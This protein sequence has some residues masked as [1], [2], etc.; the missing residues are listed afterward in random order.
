[1]AFGEGWAS[2]DDFG[3]NNESKKSDGFLDSLYDFGVDAVDSVAGFTGTWLDS[4]LNF[5]LEKEKVGYKNQLEQQN[6]V[7]GT[8]EAEQQTGA[9][10]LSPNYR[11]ISTPVG[12]V[13]SRLIWL[14]AALVVLYLVKR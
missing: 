6:S 11:Q 14:G 3:F 9:V 1:M 13:D 10:P 2:F 8:V 7:L 12:A 4:L 5:E